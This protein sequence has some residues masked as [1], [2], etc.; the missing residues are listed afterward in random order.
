[1][2]NGEPIKK[3]YISGASGRLGRSVLKRIPDAIPLVR[4][5]YGLAHERITDFSKEDL[6]EILKDAKAIL[7]LA[8]SLK[9]S[10]KKVL[11]QANYE[12]TKAIVDSAPPQCKIIFASSISVYGKKLAEIPANEKTICNPD[13]EYAKSKYASEQLIK[14]HPE[15]VI[16]RIG[17]MYGPQFGDYLMVLKKIQEGKML[18]IGDG[19][20]NIP[21]THVEDVAKVIEKSIDSGR[22]TYLVC[23]DAQTQSNIYQ[24]AASELGVDPPKKK[25][26]YA[27]AYWFSWLRNKMGKTGFT[28]EHIA[29]LGS[30]RSFDCS[31]AKEE[32]DFSPTPIKEGIAQMVSILKQL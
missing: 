8:G 1:M 31:R 4:R 12:L 10:S 32:L 2:I 30:N 29:I 23:G 18:I 11:W 3:I 15:H 20:N 16:L 22:G 13:S 6:K 27:I 14:A 5:P 19:S 25:M 21:F 9:F 17:P 7:H 28:T 24:I 26:S